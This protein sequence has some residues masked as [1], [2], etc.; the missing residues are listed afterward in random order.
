MRKGADVALPAQ[1]AVLVEWLDGVEDGLWSGPSVLSG[2]TVTE[3]AVHVLHVLESTPRV[4]GTPA[5]DR[6]LSIAEYV[7]GY[8]PAATQVR[9]REVAGAA[10]RQPADVRRALRDVLAA[11]PDRLAGLDPAAVVRAAR[12]PV[13]A[14]DYLVT[15]VVELVVH[16]DDLARSVPDR[17]PPRPDRGAL[18]VT[19]G[20]LAQVLAERAPG[21]SVEL[22]IPPYAAVQCVEGPR[23]T[24]GTPPNV[25][26]MDPLTWIRLAAGR[27]RWAEAVGGPAVRASGP[28]ADLAPWLPVL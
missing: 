21:R 27:L 18:R 10:G 1:A 19:V 12:G 16:G 11:L 22:R 9:E 28:R 13:R 5:A 25:V 7:A 3:L 4:L 24:R 20:A 15:R 17:E 6:P 26:E 14:G 8:A 2:W 23:H